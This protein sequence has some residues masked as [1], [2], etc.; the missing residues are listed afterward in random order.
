MAT[1]IVSAQS[2]PTLVRDAFRVAQQEG[3]A[4]CISNCPRMIAAYVVEPRAKPV[5]HDAIDD[6]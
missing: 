1:Q 6:F 5:L 2:I 3:R 4:R